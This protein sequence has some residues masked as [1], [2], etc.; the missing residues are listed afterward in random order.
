MN[1]TTL[2]IVIGALVLG[3]WAWAREQEMLNNG[4]NAKLQVMEGA[5]CSPTSDNS[6]GG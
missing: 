3:G 4:V 1:R 5:S 6:G 2:L